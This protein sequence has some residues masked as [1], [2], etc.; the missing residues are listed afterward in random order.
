MNEKVTEIYGIDSIQASGSHGAEVEQISVQ[1][2]E[3]ANRMLL[4][5]LRKTRQSRRKA[6]ASQSGPAKNP[7]KEHAIDQV[8]S[9]GFY[10]R[11]RAKWRH[12]GR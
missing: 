4:D 3:H 1:L 8:S 6:S 7:V 11:I 10:H 9:V 12:L 2:R 5:Y